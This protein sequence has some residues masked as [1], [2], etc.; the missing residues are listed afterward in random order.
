[1]VNVNGKSYVHDAETDDR[2]YAHYSETPYILKQVNPKLRLLTYQISMTSDD[3]FE[4]CF[5][6][7]GIS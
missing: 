1:M 2:H 5:D 4:I 6:S 3:E 7:L